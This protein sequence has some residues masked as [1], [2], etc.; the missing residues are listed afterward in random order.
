MA[1]LGG[2]V[3]P[4]PPRFNCQRDYLAI[5]VCSLS[6]IKSDSNDQVYLDSQPLFKTQ[7]Q[8]TKQTRGGEKNNQKSFQ[9]FRYIQE[10][11]I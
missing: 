8:K 3:F 7:T 11:L 10:Y 5:T 1:F 2:F 4:N 9:L 6:A